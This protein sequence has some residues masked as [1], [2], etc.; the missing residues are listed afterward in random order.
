M[1]VQECEQRFCDTLEPDS[2]EKSNRAAGCHIKP[3]R[4]EMN[5]RLSRTTR[6]SVSWNRRALGRR[7]DAASTSVCNPH[8]HEL[9][10]AD[11]RVQNF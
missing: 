9:S 1:F 4:I 10:V 8:R 7:A 3:E 11:E 2:A 6:N 5:R